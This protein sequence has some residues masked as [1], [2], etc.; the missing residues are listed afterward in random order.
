MQRL[1]ALF[2]KAIETRFAIVFGYA[3]FPGDALQLYEALQRRIQRAVAYA[4]HLFGTR[5]DRAG[6]RMTVRLAE[7][8]RLQNEQIQGALEQV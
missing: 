5:L 7:E 1:T 8:Q 6:D 3:V 2:C 4:Q